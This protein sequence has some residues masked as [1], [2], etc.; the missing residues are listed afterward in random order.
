VLPFPLIYSDS[1]NLELGQ[2]IFPAQKYRLIHDKLLADSSPE[3]A[4]VCNP[5]DFIEP[6]PATLDDLHLAH[7]PAWIDKLQR[8]QLTMAEAMRLEIPISRRLLE[9]L[10][11]MTGGS[12]LAAR[13]AL[14]YGCGFNIGGG[15]HHAF[16]NHGE[17]FCAINDVAVAVRKVQQEGA[18]AKVLIVDCDVHHGNGTASIFAG[19]ADV[20]TFSIHQRENYPFEKP[21]STLDVDLD[22]LT[23][24]KEYLEKLEEALDRIFAAFSP[25]LIFYLAGADPYAED[26]LG[27]LLLTR[28]GLA[29]RDRMVFQK[30][31]GKPVAVV[32]AG[33]Y[34]HRTGDTVEIHCNTVREAVQ[35]ALKRG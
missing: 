18:A 12:I 1:Y 23:C 21:P 34:A 7:D 16:R 26:Q 31:A 3:P 15:F 35:A 11:R 19:D 27:G 17:G 13:H 14:R 22:D 10:W 4:W 5:H 24:D 32:L 20:F 30:S 28:D 9:G 2:H 33:G 25:D 6:Q 8:G 29:R